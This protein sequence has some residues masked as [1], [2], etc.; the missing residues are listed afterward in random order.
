MP[1]TFKKFQTYYALEIS[2]FLKNNKAKI[3]KIATVKT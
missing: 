1:K 2:K 3:L